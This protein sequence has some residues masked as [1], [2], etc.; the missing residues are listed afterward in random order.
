M[1]GVGTGSVIVGKPAGIVGCWAGGCWVGSGWLA[2]A[3]SVC[4]TA[5]AR[6]FGSSVG[7]DSSGKLQDESSSAPVSVKAII[8]FLVM[9]KLL[10]VSR[11]AS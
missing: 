1:T 3:S 2:M 10:K 7:L 6:A 5:V 9:I 8:N 11:F 4:A